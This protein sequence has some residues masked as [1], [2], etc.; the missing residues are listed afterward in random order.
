MKRSATFSISVILFVIAPVL[1]Q[2]SDQPQEAQLTVYR[3][4][5]FHGSTLAP[6]VYLDDKQVARLHNGR[7]FSLKTKPGKHRLSSSAKE[8]P[9]EIGLK[10]GET[11]YLE[12]V[13]KQGTWRGGG[14]LIP[15][16]S[17]DATSAI[18]KLRPADH[19]DIF[20]ETP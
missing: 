6:S 14:L 8:P 5:H 11:A 9:L 4:K 19:N 15:T 2:I 17:E 18:K 10:P 16:P 20:A 3:P 13:V 1:G 7:Y 12:M